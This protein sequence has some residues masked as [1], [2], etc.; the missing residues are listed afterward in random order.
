[1]VFTMTNDMLAT[2]GFTKFR[3]ATAEKLNKLREFFSIKGTLLM[4]S[5]ELE[6]LE[7]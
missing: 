7:L 6:S 1:M 2:T 5:L 4:E 3:T